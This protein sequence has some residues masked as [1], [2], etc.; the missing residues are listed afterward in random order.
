M[1]V[2]GYGKRASGEM[3]VGVEEEGDDKNSSGNRA[4]K[5]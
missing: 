1:V 4:H 5:G 2:L 3:V